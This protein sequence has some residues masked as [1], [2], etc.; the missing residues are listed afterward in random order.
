MAAFR[1]GKVV[2]VDVAH[3][4]LVKL[5]VEHDGTVVTATA[6][7]AMVGPI[8][9]GDEVVM[10]TTGI[11]LGLGTGGEAFVL[12]NLSGE[13]PR[14]ELPGHIVK[15]RYTPW[16]VPVESVEAP[17][18][19]HHDVL[20]QMASMEGTP[21]VAC[22]LHSQL[23]GVAAGVKASRPEARVGY[24]MTD[25]AALPIA[26]SDLV[27]KLVDRR[28]VDVTCTCGHA[29]GGDLEAVN[30]FSAMIAT[31]LVGEADVV[32]VAMGP[33]VVGTATPLGFTGIEQGQAIDAATAL[34]ARAVGC[35]RVSFHDDRERHSGVSHHTLTALKVG[36]RSRC[37]VALPLLDEA[38]RDIIR[39]QLDEAGITARHAVLEVDGRP[40]M[41]LLR[42]QD[43]GVSSMGRSLDEIPE[44]FEAAA[45]AG[46]L[47]A[48]YA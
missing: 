33:G 5:S 13:G 18:S 1:K 15:L 4:D 36:A 6:F 10:N 47:A 46:A 25:G 28:L 43:L 26:W 17:E 38:R 45:A 48:S 9:P 31:K 41:D 24:V 3:E 19:P 12:W 16:Q 30:V 37:E 11:E 22:S 32:V 34:G 35:L 29:F 21:V 40:G 27:R 7:P 14:D 42:R 23:A 44:L 20:A 2:S 39:K 8:A